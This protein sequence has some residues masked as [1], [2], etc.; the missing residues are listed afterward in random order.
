MERLYVSRTV[1]VRKGTARETVFLLLSN[2]LSDQEICTSPPQVRGQNYTR[3][4]SDMMKMEHGA[5][6]QGPELGRTHRTNSL[7]K[8]LKWAWKH[9]GKSIRRV[10]R[11]AQS[12]D[13]LDGKTSAPGL[14]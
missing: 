14:G 11:R 3:V 9:E 12:I 10:L 1:N 8:W 13:R 2:G 5:P 6:L 4:S 7:G